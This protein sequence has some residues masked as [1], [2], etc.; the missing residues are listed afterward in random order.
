MT[1]EKVELPKGA[2]SGSFSSYVIGFI[3]SLALTLVAY[4]V[5][6]Q[7]MFSKKVLILTIVGLAFVQMIIQLIFF[8]HLTKE[9]KPRWNLQIFLAMF[10]LIAIIVGGSLW[11]MFNLDERVMPSM[12]SPKDLH[13]QE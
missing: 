12:T 3:L 11:I 6:A 2:L 9:A 5:I 7:H 1:Q 4:L 8:F 13:H 10:F